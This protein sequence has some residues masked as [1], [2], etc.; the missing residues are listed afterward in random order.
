MVINIDIKEGELVFTCI[1]TIDNLE[2]Q[3]TDLEK[4]KS[5]IG[6]RNAKKRLALIYPDRHTLEID[7]QEKEYI[8]KL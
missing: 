3:N 7:K 1:N 5:G 4:G 8:V 6:L 2:T